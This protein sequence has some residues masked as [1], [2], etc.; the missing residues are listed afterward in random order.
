MSQDRQ[1]SILRHR[2]R[3]MAHDLETAKKELRQAQ[4]AVALW[5]MVCLACAYVG[6]VF[7]VTLALQ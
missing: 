4:D 2:N 7:G 3:T 6:F 1:I 5:R